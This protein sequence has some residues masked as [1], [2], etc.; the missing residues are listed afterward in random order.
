MNKFGTQASMNL[1]EAHPV[2]YHST[3]WNIN[4]KTLV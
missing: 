3:F 4:F 2:A 1:S